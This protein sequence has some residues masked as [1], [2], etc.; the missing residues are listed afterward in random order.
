MK[1]NDLFEDIKTSGKPVSQAFDK[2]SDTYKS[3]QY[4]FAAQAFKEW[5]KKG[6][7][8]ETAKKIRSEHCKDPR[9]AKAFD[10]MVA[11]GKHYL[12]DEERK[13]VGL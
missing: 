6:M 8:P 3:E 1:L 9:C 10:K 13:D 12:S 5:K 2:D 4:F 11:N 7:N